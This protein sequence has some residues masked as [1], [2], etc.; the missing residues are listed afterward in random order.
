LCVFELFFQ[1]VCGNNRA[2]IL[3][4]CKGCHVSIG[5]CHKKWCS[6]SSFLNMVGWD[7]KW[8]CTCNK[9]LWDL[10]AK[11]RLEEFQHLLFGGCHLR[12]RSLPPSLP[13]VSWNWWPKRGLQIVSKYTWQGTLLVLL[14]VYHH[15]LATNKGF[16]VGIQ[17]R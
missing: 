17:G 6:E 10:R 12:Y 3:A 15:I 7:E 2:N 13:Q 11:M 4:S 1:K 5:Q 16:K 14:R 8:R 9:V